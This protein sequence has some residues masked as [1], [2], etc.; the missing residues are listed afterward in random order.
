MHTIMA[1]IK[2]MQY[3]HPNHKVTMATALISVSGGYLLYC[4]PA[5][6]RLDP[7]LRRQP[8]HAQANSSLTQEVQRPL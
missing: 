6:T 5:K 7:V 4:L 1:K 3:D 8:L 2:S